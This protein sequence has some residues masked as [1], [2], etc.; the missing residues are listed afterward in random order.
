MTSDSGSDLD[1]SPSSD[2]EIHNVEDVRAAILE[3]GICNS[4]LN[5]LISILKK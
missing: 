3:S 2:F 5:S 1:I 4:R